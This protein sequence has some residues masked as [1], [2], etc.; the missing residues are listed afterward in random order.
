MLQ[1][2][3]NSKPVDR[4]DGHPPL[5]QPINVSDYTIDHTWLCSIKGFYVVEPSDSPYLN[6]FY[7]G[8][9]DKKGVPN[10]IGRMVQQYANSSIHIYDGEFKKGR[11]HGRIRSH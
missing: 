7:K 1:D 11:R 4:K 5:F 2:L 9:T 6:Y 10:G 3:F 8:Q